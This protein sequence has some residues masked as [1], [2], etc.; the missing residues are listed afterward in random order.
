[1]ENSDNKDTQ[2]NNQISNSAV[3]NKD[4]NNETGSNKYV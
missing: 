2:D 1:M 3:E 4:S